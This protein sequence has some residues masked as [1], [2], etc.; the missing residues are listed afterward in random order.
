MER[1]PRRTTSLT[2]TPQNDIAEARGLIGVF[3]DRVMR[4]PVTSIKGMV[5]HCLG[6]SGAVEAAVL[7]LTV[8][9]GVIPPTIHH[10]E[11]DAECPIDVVANQPRETR[12]CCGVST[13]L[14]FGGNDSAIVMRALDR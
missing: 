5:G 6:A 9:R 8:S 2:A 3:G 4:V 10:E 7:A 12:V 11:T 14:G 1:P 13:S